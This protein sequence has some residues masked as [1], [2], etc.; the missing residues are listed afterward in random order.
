M[1]RHAPLSESDVRHYLEA[2]VLVAGGQR[3]WA[4]RHGL[5]QAYVGKVINGRRPPGVRLLAALGL[6]ELPPAYAPA[7]DRS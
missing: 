2:T 1:S 6:R 7:E 3:A 5:S 4:A